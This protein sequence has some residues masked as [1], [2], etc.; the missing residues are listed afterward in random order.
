[1][2]D[3]KV[4]ATQ[5]QFV[6]NVKALVSEYLAGTG[7]Y[8]HGDSY[9]E[10]L[11]RVAYLKRVIEDND[12]YRLFYIDGK[13]VKRESD[14]QTMFRLTWYATSFDVNSEVNN[15]RGPV[16][17]KVSKGKR[18]KSLVEFKLAT[19]TGLR[20]NLGN[21]VKIYENANDT[22]KSIKVILYFSLS[23]FESVTKILRE[24]KLD[25]RED[26]VLIDA[27]RDTKISASKA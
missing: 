4:R 3:E 20:R 15:G 21:Q 25:G 14:L 19:N 16:D 12:G 1:M 17:Y 23:E 9:H 5:R 2:S 26:V 6:E 10:S 18:D 27:S 8:E 7:F 24:L 22:P 13:P 11:E